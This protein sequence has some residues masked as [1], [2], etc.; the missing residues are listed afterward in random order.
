MNASRL[1]MSTQGA[2]PADDLIIGAG[3]CAMAFVDT[4]LRESAE[5]T[6]LMVHRQ[7]LAG[8]HWNPTYPFVRLLKSSPM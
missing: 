5:V 8:G 6:G 2:L 4:R 7:H 3:A 1:S